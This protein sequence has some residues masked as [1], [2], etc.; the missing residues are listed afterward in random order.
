MGSSPTGPTM[1]HIIFMYIQLFYIALTESLFIQILGIL[2][3]YAASKYI[4][5]PRENWYY[6][7]DDT[8]E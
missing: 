4:Y 3:F 6:P 7:E 5:A 8:K 2:V 1:L